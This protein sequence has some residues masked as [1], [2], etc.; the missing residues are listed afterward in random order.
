MPAEDPPRFIDL[1]GPILQEK[2]QPASM[3]GGLDP[4][5]R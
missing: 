3:K 1:E 5:G 4:G 2:I